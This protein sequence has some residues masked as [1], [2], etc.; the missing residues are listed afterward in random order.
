MGDRRRGEL[1]FSNV[2]PRHIRRSNL[3]VGLALGKLPSVNPGYRASY[4]GPS[5]PLVS[6]P[7]TTCLGGLLGEISSQIN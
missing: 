6:Q 4:P 7:T 1:S 2:P 3:V 5:L